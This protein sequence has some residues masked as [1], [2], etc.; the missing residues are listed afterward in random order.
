MVRIA[1]SAK[2]LP[3]MKGNSY[4]SSEQIDREFDAKAICIDG[5]VKIT[6]QKRSLSHLRN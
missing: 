6:C 3:S 1:L 2:S 4:L 5:D